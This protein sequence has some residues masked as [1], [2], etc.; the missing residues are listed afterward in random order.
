MTAVAGRLAGHLDGDH[1]RHAGAVEGGERARPAGE[2]DLLHGLADLHR[3]LHAEARPTAGG[4]RR[5]VL[6]LL[7][8]D[9]D[10]DEAGDEQVPLVREGVGERDRELGDR[11]QLAAEVLEDVHEHGD[12]EGDQRDQHDAARSDS[13]TAGY[14]IADLTW[15]RS[16]SSASSWVA[17]RLQ[18]VLEDAAGLTGADHGDVERVEDLR[19]ALERVGEREAGL[20]VLADLAE[21]L[22]ELGV[23]DLLLEHVE[24]AQQRHARRDHHRQLPGHDRSGRAALTFLDPMLISILRPVA[25]S[26]S[27]W[28]VRPRPLSSSVTACLEAPTIS[29]L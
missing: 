8:A 13:T 22:L 7:E 14:I 19:V 12:D 24:R 10:A 4:P 1:D 3:D 18:R 5:S 16:E 11:R 20:D 6:P 28:T 21:R 15:R 9:D 29:P 26:S 17:M 25:F 27:F 2:G 23:L